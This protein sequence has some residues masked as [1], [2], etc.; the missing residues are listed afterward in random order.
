MTTLDRLNTLLVEHLRCEASFRWDADLC[1][2]LGADSLDLVEIA[3]KLE[4]QFG[5]QVS[6]HAA[7]RWRTPQDVLDTVGGMVS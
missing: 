7:D 1:A 4:E 2:E 5:V 6:D 3:L